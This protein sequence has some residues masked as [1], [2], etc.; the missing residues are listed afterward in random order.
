MHGESF[1][2][3]FLADETRFAI[4]VRGTVQGVG[5]RPFVYRAAR[6]ESL[7]GW[8]LN[9]SDAVRIE[10][11][12]ERQ[13]IARFLER[14]RNA[15]PPPVRIA[16]IET[17]EIRRVI[18][19]SGTAEFTIRTSHAAAAPAPTIPADLAT[20]EACRAE[21]DDP[22]QRRYRYPFTNCTNCGPRWSI[23]E[24][25]PYDRPRTSM[26][27]FE[28]CDDCRREY[29]D[30]ADRRFHAQPI[31]CPE[32]GPRLKLLTAA[33]EVMATGDGALR[34]A[35]AELQAGR[36]LAVKGLGGFQLLA[37]A[38]RA[39]AVARLRERKRRPEKPLAVMMPDLDCVRE[40]CEI[41]DREAEALMSPAAPILLLRR[42][43]DP[44]GNSSL[45][46]GVAPDNPYLGVMLPYTP[47][48]HLIAIGLPRPVV[49][50]SGNVSEEPMAISTDEAV[51]RLGKIA[52]CILTHDRPIVRPVDDS[53]ARVSDDGL[54]VLRRARGYAPL[55]IRL[56]QAYPTVL[57]V[58]GHLKNTVAMN[59]GAEVVFSPHIG[60]LDNLLSVEVHRQAIEDLTA[61]F[62]VTPERVACDLHPDY[63]STR[64]AEQ[65]AARWD[66]PLIRVQHHHAHVAACM[67]EHHLQGSGLGVVVGRHG[68]RNGRDGLGRR[69]PVVLRARV[70]TPGASAHLSLARRGCSRTRA[71]ACG[72]GG[73]VRTVGRRRSADRGT[74]V[75]QGGTAD[76]AGGLAPAGPVSPNEQSGTSVRCGRRAVRS[77]RSRNMRLAPG[78]GCQET[79]PFSDR[80]IASRSRPRRRWPWNSRSTKPSRMPTR[81]RSKPGLA[82]GHGRPETVPLSK[83]TKPG[84]A[85][86]HGR[87]EKVPLSSAIGNRS[88]AASFPTGCTE[89]RSA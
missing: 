63:A 2:D 19:A 29:E 68:L 86:G 28:M 88:F 31:A 44:P 13:A 56:H 66:V 54:R 61:F 5:F 14:L 39:D 6:D 78:H 75:H 71:A 82:P 36:I 35:V 12:G 1:E 58:G 65:L 55:P 25:L 22:G 20:C 89:C 17:R 16:G 83:P 80:L 47:L 67:A 38:T 4:I 37:D 24:R 73:I 70:R 79:V 43:V 52:D 10:V 64:L 77:A 27:T 62:A 81:C 41:S 50:T 32:C 9:D 53:V 26:R 33:G 8:V 3:D 40:Y 84:L 42:H 87:P 59:L 18:E 69:D 60:D 72:A 85:P 23:I 11:Q 57:A 45:S 7:V 46:A 15:A 74:L 51:K 34:E 48:H 30:P 76:A 49:C 21:I